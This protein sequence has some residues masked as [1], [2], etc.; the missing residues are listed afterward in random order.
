M[1]P[2]IYPR[3]QRRIYLAEWR[4]KR[5]LTQEVL[6]NR[7][8]TTDVTVSRWETGK[9]L[10]NTNVMA[11]IAEALAIEPEDLYHDPDRPTP[12]ALMRDQPPEIVEQAIKLL[13]A[14]RR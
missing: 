7:L 6:A 14:I 2:R 5:G 12:N 4:E 13:T 1:P 9:A 3:R 8:G 10:L 11:A